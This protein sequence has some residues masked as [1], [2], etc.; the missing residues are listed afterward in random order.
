MIGGSTPALR[1]SM[2]ACNVGRQSIS[3][4]EKGIGYNTPVSVALHPGAAIDCGLRS[5]HHLR[6]NEF[7]NELRC[8]IDRRC[9]GLA[10]CHRFVDRSGLAPDDGHRRARA[11]E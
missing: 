5:L 9:N 8:P 11:A 4:P 2:I 10:E 6:G 3:D 7:S 1:A